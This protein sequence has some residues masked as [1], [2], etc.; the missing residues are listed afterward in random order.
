MVADTKEFNLAHDDNKNKNEVELIFII[1]GAN[2]SLD[3]N[4]NAPLSVAVAKAL[5]D[6]GNTGRPASECKLGMRMGSCLIHS[7][8]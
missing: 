5:A 8:S 1:N 3:A 2:F 4:V 6:S 7:A